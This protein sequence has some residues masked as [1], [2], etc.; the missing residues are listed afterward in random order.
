M[1]VKLA[2]PLFLCYQIRHDYRDEPTVFF[3]LP[4]E[5]RKILYTTNL[6]ANLNRKIRKYTEKMVNAD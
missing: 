3:E 5:I 4:I 1:R 2:C 6:I